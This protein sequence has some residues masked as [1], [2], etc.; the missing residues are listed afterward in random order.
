M[1]NININLLPWR[2]ELK[3]QQ[4]REFM[5]MLGLA[6]V[7][8]SGLM[9]LIHIAIGR[10]ITLQNEDNDY[11]KREIKI[12]DQQIEQ[13]KLLDKEK[14]QLL[15]KMQVIQELQAS[16]PEV[17]RLFDGIVRLIPPGLYLTSLSR[18]G[19]RIQIDGKAESNTRVSTLMRNIDASKLLSDPILSLIQADDQKEGDKGIKLADRMIG[20][21]LQATEMGAVSINAPV[22]AAVP[23]QTSSGTA[24]PATVPVPAANTQSVPAMKK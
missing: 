7:A 23:G 17:V 9:L 16:R 18:T 20:F 19:N 22:V 14:K 4:K 12:L 24:A 21:N 11:L 2:E 6:V 8:A 15:E 3:E 5:S 10:Q 1:A 13:I